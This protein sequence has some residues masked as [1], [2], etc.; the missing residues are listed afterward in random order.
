MGGIGAPVGYFFRFEFL[1]DGTGVINIF[2]KYRPDC[3]MGVRWNSEWN[4][5]GPGPCL[6]GQSIINNSVLARGRFYL[7]FME[8]SPWRLPQVSFCS[9]FW[10]RGSFLRRRGRQESAPER[11]LKHTGW[12]V[13]AFRLKLR[14]P[15]A[16]G[17][18][19]QRQGQ[20]NTSQG[21]RNAEAGPEKY[22]GRAGEGFLQ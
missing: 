4:Q 20:R 9:P 8:M 15:R 21:R 18:G 22:Q 16:L 12:A 7:F 3:H 14:T 19:F 6:C 10:S 17:K 13:G 2:K 5:C 1:Q 11:F